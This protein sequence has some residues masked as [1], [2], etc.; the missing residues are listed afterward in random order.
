MKIKFIGT[1]TMGSIE[2]SNQSIEI[3][4][5][6]FDVGSGTVKKMEYLKWYTKD[7]NYLVIS[8]FHADHIFDIPNFLIGRSIRKEN[9]RKLPII[10]GKGLKERVIEI[11][12]LAFGDGIERKYDNFENDY[13]VEFIELGNGESYEGDNFKITAYELEHGFCKPILGFLLEKEGKKVSYATDTINCDNLKKLINDSECVLIDSTNI[14]GTKSHIGLEEVVELKEKYNDKR[15]MAIH[16]GDYDHN[17]VYNI[18]FPDDG[19]IIEI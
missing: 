5:I 10:G 2:R 14:S 17:N 9:T 7:V 19:D 8:H 12:Y 15:F 4:D 18:E 3:D 1:G 11:F 13:N 6:L 16:R